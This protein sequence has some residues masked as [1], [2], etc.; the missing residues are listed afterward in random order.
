[1]LSSNRAWDS[2]DT[3]SLAA[4][5]EFTG[6]N[7]IVLSVDQDQA[8]RYA[9]LHGNSRA[10]EVFLICVNDLKDDPLRQ[11]LLRNGRAEPGDKLFYLSESTPGE[12]RS[13][14]IRVRRTRD[15][16]LPVSWTL[17]VQSCG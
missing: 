9:E 2:S 8:R 12:G 3:P 5:V 6:L 15:I 13:W 4:G 11:S 10:P 16:W 7:G 17:H 14:L 1:M